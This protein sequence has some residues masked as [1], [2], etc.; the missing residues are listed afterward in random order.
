MVITQSR[1][2]CRNAGPKKRYKQ[3]MFSAL[4]TGVVIDVENRSIQMKESGDLL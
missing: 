4:L 3:K 1:P 2:E